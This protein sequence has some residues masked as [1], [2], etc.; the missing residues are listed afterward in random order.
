M[1]LVGTSTERHRTIVE[2]AGRPRRRDFL[3]AGALIATAVLEGTLRRDLSWPAATTVLTVLLLAGLPWRRR[4]PLAFVIITTASTAALGAVQL[5]AGVPPDGMASMFALILGPYSLFRWAAR[6]SRI[7]GGTVL[8]VGVVLT[9]IFRPE[10]GTG[11]GTGTESIISGIAGVLF[12]GSACLLGALRR[13]RADRLAKEMAV[14]RAQEREA[15]AR[16]LHDAIGHHVS[17]IAIRAQAAA[18]RAAD[19]AVVS[20]SLRVIEN[21]A[22]AVLDEM[23]I[24]VRALRMPADY[25][26]PADIAAIQGL[27]DD[28]PPQVTVHIDTVEAPSEVVAGTLHRIAQEAVTNAR[29]HAS[30]VTAIAIAVR[31]DGADALLEVID[32]GRGS[33]AGGPPG[34]GLRGMRERAA[35]L[36]GSIDAGPHPAGGWMLRARIPWKAS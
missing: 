13:E 23:R 29:R 32:D 16:D 11:T 5:I 30:G 26:P 35:L 9:T 22:S 4:H 27:A 3:L 1:P 10:T 21:E 34:F 28:G 25:E 18:L 2:S 31:T 36:G 17:A 33:V 12:V 24:L 20:E 8:A 15:L 14:V 6:R 7:L 19:P